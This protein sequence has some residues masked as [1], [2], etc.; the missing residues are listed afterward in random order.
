MLED[1]LVGHDPPN[2]PGPRPAA[3]RTQ[4]RRRSRWRGMVGN[5][6]ASLITHHGGDLW[7]AFHTGLGGTSA[8]HSSSTHKQIMFA[9]RFSVAL[10]PPTHK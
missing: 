2:R 5:T 3:A 10:S 4:R 1:D 6:R 8:L 9:H 7:G